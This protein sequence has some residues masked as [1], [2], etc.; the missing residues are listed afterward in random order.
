VTESF[1]S[2][3]H[4]VEQNLNDHKADMQVLRTLLFFY[5]DSLS[6]YEFT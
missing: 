4:E 2:F 6:W 1:K 3:K 5:V